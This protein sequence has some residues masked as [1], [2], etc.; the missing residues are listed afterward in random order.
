MPNLLASPLAVPTGIRPT[1]A[2]FIGRIAARHTGVDGM[3]IRRASN[4][5]VALVSSEAYLTSR[6]KPG[7]ESDRMAGVPAAG[8]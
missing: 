2:L 8:W 7:P 1:P 3:S 5:A 6:D 4:R